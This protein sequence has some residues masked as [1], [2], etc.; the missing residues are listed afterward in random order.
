[1]GLFTPHL[2]QA[3]ARLIPLWRLRLVNAHTGETFDGPF[4][5][6]VGPLPLAMADLSEF[7]R[8]H[9]SG[10][11]IG[12]DIGVLDFL[13]SIMEAAGAT[14]ATVLSAYRTPETNATLARTTFGVAEHSQHMYGRALDVRLPSRNHEAVRAAREM[15]LGG[16]GW[17]PRS[18]FFHIDTGSVRNWTL[19]ERGLDA[20]LSAQP[21]THS[22]NGRHRVVD[23]MSMPGLESSGRPLD[24]LMNSGHPLPGTQTS[25]QPLASLKESGKPLVRPDRH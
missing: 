13:A 18:G 4:R 11:K 25:G 7:L 5:D 23:H 16:V 12:Y 15:K 6:D 10:E 24:P 3:S 22:T 17:Y 20:L 21:W 19:D 1:M 14:Y 8:D 2:A 9:H